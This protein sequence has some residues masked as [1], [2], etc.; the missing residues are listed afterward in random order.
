MKVNVNKKIIHFRKDSL[1]GFS[2]YTTSK[3]IVT[4]YDENNYITSVIIEDSYKIKL[5]QSIKI[6]GRRYLINIIQRVGNIFY[7]VQEP[8]TKT[9]QFILPLIGKNHVYYSFNTDLYNVYISECYTQLFLVYKFNPGTEYLDLESRLSKHPNF[10]KTIDPNPEL[11]VN[12]FEIAQ[13][14]WKD[15][16]LIMEGKYSKI[17]DDTKALIYLFHGLDTNSVVY[18][19]LF[20]VDSY[21][22]ALESKLSCSIPENIELMTKPVL[23]KELWNYQSIL[24]PSGTLV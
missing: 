17:H 10:V 9:A 16:A 5:K 19:V 3:D 6:D 12:Q 11:V 4:T 18:K 22:K 23:I 15:V 14:F 7:C 1:R 13:V 21:R 20:N 24:K 2:M 8:I